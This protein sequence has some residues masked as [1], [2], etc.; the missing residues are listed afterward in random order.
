MAENKVSFYK[1]KLENYKTLSEANKN[2][3][4][5][6]AEEGVIMLDD[7]EYVRYN[8]SDEIKGKSIETTVGGIKEGTAVSE[9]KGKSFS[10]LFDTILF[11]VKNPVVNQVNSITWGMQ[12]STVKLGT[13]VVKPNAI[14]YTQGSW[15]NGDGSVSVYTGSPTSITYTYSINGN[16]YKSPV[17]STNTPDLN[18]VTIYNQ[19]ASNTYKVEV[20]YSEGGIPKNSKGEEITESIKAGSDKIGQVEA[21]NIS[22]TRTVNV[23]V[24][25]YTSV[26]GQLS[27]KEGNLIDGVHKASGITVSFTIPAGNSNYPQW[28]SIPGKITAIEQENS[29]S[30]KYESVY[31]LVDKDKGWKYVSDPRSFNGVDID[32][33]KYIWYGADRDAVKLKVTFNRSK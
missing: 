22:T 24:P 6:F 8:P 32:Y 3:A 23:S 2:G 31:H 12:N 13:S 14:A 1:G 19:L 10:E 15:A 29:I 17:N 33:N 5:Y 16:T 26:A 20:A 9:L 21:G 11:P 30:G 18:N 4:I 28:F 25:Y 7:Q 27:E